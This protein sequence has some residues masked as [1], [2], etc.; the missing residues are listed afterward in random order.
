LQDAALLD[1]LAAEKLATLAHE[2]AGE[3]WKWIEASVNLPYGVATGL[4]ALAGTPI[5]LTEEE[6][7]TID[8]L[9]AEL[10]RLEMEYQDADELPDEVDE[11]LGEIETALAAFD[12]RPVHY[13]PADI[14]RAG[15]FVSIGNDGGLLTIVV[16]S[17]PK[18]KHR[19][20]IPRRTT[21]GA[22]RPARPPTPTSIQPRPLL[23]NVRLSPSAVSRPVPSKRM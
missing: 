15:V 12:E 19:L 14:A 16:T 5:D 21:Q 23:C 7:G 9:N 4:R 18:T 22:M 2:I 8:A 17:G 3:G 1:R 20:P 10:E 6:R 11:R 13:A